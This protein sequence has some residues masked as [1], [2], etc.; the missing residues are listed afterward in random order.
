MRGAAVRALARGVDGDWEGRE[1]GPGPPVPLKQTGGS[2]TL[3]TVFV[4]NR[5]T[6]FF[7]YLSE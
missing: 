6:M 1:G 3:M 4:P 2:G 7:N 5:R